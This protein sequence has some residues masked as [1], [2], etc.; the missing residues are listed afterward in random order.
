MEKKTQPHIKNTFLC[1]NELIYQHNIKFCMED[2]CVKCEVAHPP[3]KK[4]TNPN[5][6]NNYGMPTSVACRCLKYNWP[7]Q[8]DNVRVS[9]LKGAYMLD[10]Q[11]VKGDGW[12]VTQTRLQSWRIPDSQIFSTIITI[13]ATGYSPNRNLVDGPCT[14]WDR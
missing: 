13:W 9:R 3:H 5:P 2:T 7:L 8:M 12:C 4:T 14:S 1:A 11:L 6:Q 10:E